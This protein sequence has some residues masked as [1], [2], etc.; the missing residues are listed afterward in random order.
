[1]LVAHWQKGS[2]VTDMLI[3]VKWD[4]QGTRK[5]V[6]FTWI[7]EKSF[8][9]QFGWRGRVLHP[10][11]LAVNVDVMN[12]RAWYEVINRQARIQNVFKGFETYI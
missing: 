7:S 10:L 12:Q 8:I 2:E 4:Y 5:Y 9:S 3:H 1:M 11:T 6:I